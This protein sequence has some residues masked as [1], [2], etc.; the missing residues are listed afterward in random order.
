MAL[1]K[2]VSGIRGT[3]G[4]LPGENLTPSDI[5][6]F[7]S[8]YATWLKKKYTDPGVIVGRDGRISGPHISTLVIET[9]KAMGIHVIDAGLSTTPSVEVY[10]PYAKANGGIIITASHNPREWNALKFLNAQGEIISKAD[11]DEILELAQSHAM[12]FAPMDAFGSFQTTPNDIAYHVEQICKLDLVDVEAI[13]ARGFH[14]VADCINSTGAIAIPALMDALGCTF[15]LINDQI[16]GEFEHNPEPLED[17]LEDLCREVAAH[18]AMLGIAVDPDVD[19]L[20]FV[21]EHGVYMGEEYSLVAVADYIL[22]HT[23]GPCVS[24]LSSSM[25]LRDL[26]KKYGQDYSASKVGEVHVVDEMK[27]VG[28]VIGGEGN[29]GVIYPALHYGRDGLVGIALVLSHL[30]RSGRSLSELKAGFPQYAMVKTKMTFPNDV[31]AN[32][33]FERIAATYPNA[34]ID[35][36]DGVK[37]INE[38]SWIHLRASNT[39]PIVRIYAEATTETEAEKLAAD[40]KDKLLAMNKK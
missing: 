22:Q 9:L 11:G 27:R 19:R 29:G 31:D 4:G 32:A 7:I 25:A 35:R 15:T 2:S 30:A 23:P 39:E 37:I 6:G 13:R 12:E 33:L 10:V 14:I 5:V 20:A 28:A 24:N 17:H 3:I 16:N 1:I 34:E 38:K 36:R 26:A 21:D 8:G 40:A 18:G